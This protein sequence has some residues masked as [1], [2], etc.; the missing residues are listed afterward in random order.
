MKNLIEQLTDLRTRMLEVE[1]RYIFAG[2]VS[3]SNFSESYR[4]LLHY[5]VLRSHDL[6][7]L[8]HELAQLGLS[9]L[10]RMESHVL[11]SVDAVLYALRSLSNEAPQENRSEPASASFDV[12]NRL[13][14]MHSRDLLGPAPP[15]RHPRIVVTLPSTSEA[16]YTLIAS[17][18]QQGME[19]ARINC[20]HDGPVA[21]ERMIRHIR[22]AEKL[23]GRACR[24]LMDLGGPKLRTGPIEPGPSVSKVRPERDAFGAVVK[25]ARIWLTAREQPVSAPTAAAV[26]IPVESA[27]MRRLRAGDRIHFID[28][29]AASREMTVVAVG[30]EGCWAEM[31]KTAYFVPGLELE[32]R[33]SRTTARDLAVVGDLPP[34]PGAIDLAVGEMLILSRKLKPGRQ[35]IRDS[36]GDVL[37]P[38]QISCTLPEIFN[39]VQTGER[40]WFDDG[41]IGGVIE[42]VE[43]D[44]IFV[45][46]TQARVAG[47]KLQSDK[48]INLPDSSL[49][50][51]ALTPKDIEDL[52]FVAAHADMVGLSFAQNASDVED[53]VHRLDELG[54]KDLGIVFKIETRRGFQ[55]LPAMLLEGMKGASL[56][57]MIARGDLAVECGFE[58]M[59]EVQ[60]EILWICEAA[61]CPVIWATQVLESL[62]KAGIPSRAEITDAAMGH[63]AEAVMLNKGPHI[64]R[65]VQTLDDILQRMEAHQTKK[66]SMLRELS[67]ARVFMDGIAKPDPT[68]I[69]EKQAPATSDKSPSRTRGHEL[70]AERDAIDSVRKAAG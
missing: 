28:S 36:S 42:T 13:L 2:G 59:A 66:Q 61:H 24:I 11:A 39:D 54:R 51:P 1:R 45:R 14:E 26:S 33:N 3:H 5:L 67:L 43:E 70:C 16:D 68:S 21:W 64:L 29:R 10:G 27:W 48:G 65:A 52:A 17:L 30:E 35:A 6:R 19:V 60:E 58:R 31:H 37:T 9:S 57:V 8:Q 53:L 50:L 56:G 4:N 62:A 25:P 41:K 7:P 34:Q 44:R 47:E 46:I 63:R 18:V 20:A 55:E 38:A 40:I 12:G 23:H 32:R 15:R 22:R 69:D 49:R